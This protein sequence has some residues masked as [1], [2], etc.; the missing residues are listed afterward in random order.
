MRARRSWTLRL[1]VLLAGSAVSGCGGTMSLDM[2][3]SPAL[4]RLQQADQWRGIALGVAKLED[5]RSWIDPT[6]PESLGYV[7]QQGAFRFGL[8]YDGRKY[9]PVSDLVQTLFVEEFTR[10]GV[11]AKA[12]PKILTKDNVADTVEAGRQ[13][14]TAYVLGGR[15]LVFEIVN[16][17]G[18]WTVTSRRSV[19]LEI[20]LVRVQGGDVAL[21]SN[22]SLTDRQDEGMGVRHST[23]VDRLMNNVFRRV[24][25][26]VVEQVTAK[27]ALAPRDVDVRITLVSR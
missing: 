26:Q 27:L 6:N 7:M 24:V 9:V 25:T 12:I 10:A 14:G 5:R 19:T 18:V 16:E 23:N 13:A 15:V 21:D 11:E 22:V 2:N 20:T 17:T 4:Y 3:Y 1:A 8:T